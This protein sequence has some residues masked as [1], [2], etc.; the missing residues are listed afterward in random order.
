MTNEHLDWPVRSPTCAARRELAA[1]FALPFAEDM[2]DWE[3]EVADAAR[4]DEL[5][6]VYCS[7]NLNDDER[8]S[9]MEML[10]QCA[11]DMELQSNYTAAWSTIEPL[12]LSRP[13]LHRSTVA[14]WA[15]LRGTE[16][17][18][19]FRVSKNMHKVWSVIST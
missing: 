1:R 3:W 17:E 4:F 9:L 14:Y 16:P 11:E 10:I 7:A 19:Q 8:F 12:L 18:A 6:S 13:D 15:C 5:I 2:Q